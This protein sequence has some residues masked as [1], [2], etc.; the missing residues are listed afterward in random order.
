MNNS[1]ILSLIKEPNPLLHQKSET[2]DLINFETKVFC[3]SLIATMKYYNGLGIAAVQVGC[4]KKI[5]AIDMTNIDSSCNI[6]LGFKQGPQ[7]LIN[8]EIIEKSKE[9]KGYIEGC[10]SFGNIFPEVIRCN[11][12]KVK[13]QDLDKK[14]NFLEV[15]DSIMAACLQHEID[16]T[17]GIVFLDRISKIKRDF[18]LKKYLKWKKLQLKKVIS[19]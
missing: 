8:P 14:I 19:K 7:V 3:S 5:I 10:L 2:V 13:Y 11:K 1:K 16:H 15:S 4:L 18:M 9:Q 12:I 6:P 17:N